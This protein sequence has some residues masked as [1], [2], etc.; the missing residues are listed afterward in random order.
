LVNDGRRYA[1]FISAVVCD[2]FRALGHICRT[3]ST[4]NGNA[5]CR[6]CSAINNW[7]SQWVSGDT[8][9]DAG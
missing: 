4:G 7:P 9:C 2:G 8:H 5:I 1:H 6:Y 3:G